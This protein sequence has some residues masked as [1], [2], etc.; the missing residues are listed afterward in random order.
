MVT[1]DATRVACCAK[2]AST[3]FSFWHKIFA[4]T[5]DIRWRVGN[6]VLSTLSV[7]LGYPPHTSIS[8]VLS[9]PQGNSDLS[10]SMMKWMCLERAKAA[11]QCWTPRFIHSWHGASRQTTAKWQV[12]LCSLAYRTVWQR[13]SE[14][15][16]APP[17][18]SWL[19][20]VRTR[21]RYMTR[22]LGS[23]L[24]DQKHCSRMYSRY[25]S[26]SNGIR[27]LKR[28]FVSR[29]RRP[30]MGFDYPNQVVAS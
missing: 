30:L 11:F 7:S 21:Q 16:I 23:C 19:L 28:A 13:P 5:H 20:D 14:P 24:V 10:Y 12:L 17:I 18:N 22:P 15:D 8:R 3:S 25:C 4:M 2:V 29:S 27:Y 26:S 9:V 6:V 1:F